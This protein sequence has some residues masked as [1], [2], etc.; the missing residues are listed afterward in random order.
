MTISVK[1]I[2]QV[3]LCLNIN[4][5]FGRETR[6]NEELNEFLREYFNLG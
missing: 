2:E 4:S 1:Y 5:V 3:R 6:K